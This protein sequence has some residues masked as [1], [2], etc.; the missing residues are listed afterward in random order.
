MLMTLRQI[1]KAR[2]FLG[3]IE[4]AQGLREM[5][6]LVGEMRAFYGNDFDLGLYVKVHNT[7]D[8]YTSE[9]N[10]LDKR[11]LKGFID[12]CLSKERNA[13]TIFCILDLMAEGEVVERKETIYKFISKVYFSYSGK[14]HFNKSIETI[15][16]VPK[17]MIMMGQYPITQETALGLVNQ[18]RLYANE[19]CAPIV[20]SPAL[21]NTQ[22][23]HFQPQIRVDSHNETNIDITTVFEN[24]RQQAADEGLSDEQYKIIMEK[25]TEL[26]ELAKSKESKGKRWA[27][28]KEFMKWLVEQGIQVAGI[29][30]PVLAQTIR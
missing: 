8:S 23:I 2:Y 22:E 16:T 24:A 15:A 30:L 20:P 25:L 28:A 27:K 18:L 10:S 7:V 6:A 19:L 5:Q 11:A 1:E 12:G 13:D 4:S 21:G 26:E 29:L 17:E 9:F 14:I 3:A